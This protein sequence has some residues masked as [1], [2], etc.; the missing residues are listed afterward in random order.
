MKTPPPYKI[1]ILMHRGEKNAKKY[2]LKAF[3]KQLETS[4]K[5]RPCPVFKKE[6]IAEKHLLIQRCQKMQSA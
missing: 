6:N 1:D 4:K 5:L 2:N 3:K